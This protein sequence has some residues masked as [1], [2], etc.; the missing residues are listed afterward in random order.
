MLLEKGK[1][2]GFDLLALGWLL[3][4]ILAYLRLQPMTVGTQRLKVT[5]Y[6][7]ALVPVNVIHV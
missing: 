5:Q 7:V 6:R 1:R 4:I 2:M 3:L